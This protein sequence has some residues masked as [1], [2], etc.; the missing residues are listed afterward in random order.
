[1]VIERDD[2]MFAL[3]SLVAVIARVRAKEGNYPPFRV[4]DNDTAFASWLSEG[5]VLAR[6]V[7]RTT[8]GVVG[9]VL[10]ATPGDYLVEFLAAVG[11]DST[12]GEFAEIG[13]LF[14]D[15]AARCQGIGQRLLAAAVTEAGSRHLRPA[16]VVRE[17]GDAA[18]HLYRAQG[19]IEAGPLSARGGHFRVFLWDS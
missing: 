10:L 7:A 2:D 3:S 17:V 11:R 15:P 4:D 19:W 8:D 5:Q 16:L 13:R 12:N 18:M 1:V 14:V 6:W 9:H